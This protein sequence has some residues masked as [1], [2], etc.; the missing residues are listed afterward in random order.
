[1]AWDAHREFVQK[2]I[3]QQFWHH[4]LTLFGI[5][6]P[7]LSS[8]FMMMLDW[9]VAL[10]LLNIVALVT[11]LGIS[12]WWH[13]FFQVDTLAK[14]GATEF[15]RQRREMQKNDITSKYEA[16][17]LK[18]Y[19]LYE[20]LQR[21]LKNRYETFLDALN[22]QQVISEAMREEFASKAYQ[23]WVSG[24]ELLAEIADILVVQSS[25]DIKMIEKKRQRQQENELYELEKI[26]NGYEENKENLVKLTRS[27][28]TLIHSYD[29]ALSQMATVT[30]RSTLKEEAS[31]PGGLQDAIDSA[32]VVQ[33]RLHKMYHDD[34][35]NEIQKNRAYK[36]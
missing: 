5:G 18:A 20:G 17:E 13:W 27:L 8:I 14:E 32:R 23:A 4:P 31:Q 1:M 21:K 2:Y 6:L 7:S 34:D 9:P 24:V 26:V 16:I 30:S 28:R 33:E 3:W 25:V 35:W 22:K 36:E 12:Y 29:L 11:L 19:P 10:Q 15:V